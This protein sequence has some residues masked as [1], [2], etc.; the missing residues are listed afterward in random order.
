M[1][2]TI[3]AV[4]NI[5]SGQTGR[6]TGHVQ[7]EGDPEALLDGGLPGG[8]RQ[9]PNGDNDQYLVFARA[10][11]DLRLDGKYVVDHWVPFDDS[12]EDVRPDKVL[13]A[14]DT[15]EE[16][17]AYA[18]GIE[19]RLYAR[20]EKP[21]N[22]PAAEW[23]ECSQMAQWF[24]GNPA[25]LTGNEPSVEF[26]QGPLVCNVNMVTGQP[27]FERLDAQ[28]RMR[29]VL[30]YTAAEVEAALD[31]LADNFADVD[32]TNSWGPNIGVMASSI[33][34]KLATVGCHLNGAQPQIGDQMQALYTGATHHNR[35]AVSAA[36]R[37]LWAS[38]SLNQRIMRPK[39][40]PSYV[41]PGAGT[42]RSGE[43]YSRS[44]G[45]KYDRDLPITEIARLIRADIKSAQKAGWLPPTLK[46]RCAQ[47]SG[48]N[49]INVRANGVSREWQRHDD[50]E[51]GWREVRNPEAEELQ[52]RLDRILNSYNHDGSETMVDYFDVRY[53]GTAQLSD[54]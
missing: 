37:Q 44:Y 43:M 17:N 42:A 1:T 52:R 13:V 35:E 45:A 14:F 28:G 3:D 53:Y 23:A 51:F 46:I 39:V 25:Y 27:D 15:A 29:P 41:P 26:P 16:A 36:L 33:S 34:E 47:G 20:V 7:V 38:Q 50:R 48:G 19:P 22:D 5:H 24:D 4:G 40:D 32:F 6:F 2:Q 9:F 54:Y 21:F 30:G 12:D 8:A 11:N 31:D 49:S 18:A 10:R